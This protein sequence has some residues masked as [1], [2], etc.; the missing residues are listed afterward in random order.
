[1]ERGSIFGNKTNGTK[2]REW[3]WFGKLKQKKERCDGRM[4]KALDRKFNEDLGARSIPTN[5]EMKR[6]KIKSFWFIIGK[7]SE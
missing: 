2:R 3:R 1:M 7:C 6:K 4:V 5:N